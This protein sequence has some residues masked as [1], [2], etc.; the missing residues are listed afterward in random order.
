MASTLAAFIAWILDCSG[1]G[2]LPITENR[3]KEA[4]RGTRN[5]RMNIMLVEGHASGVIVGGFDGWV[6]VGIGPG[7]PPG[8]SSGLT[9]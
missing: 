4:L 2:S 5:L 9:T 3:R 8:A 7:L 6:I 1:E